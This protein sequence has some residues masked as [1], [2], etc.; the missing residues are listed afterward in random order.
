MRKLLFLI[1][2]YFKVSFSQ[3]QVSLI[4][5]FSP[6]TT[7]A[8]SINKLVSVNGTLYFTVDRLIWKSDGTENGT[9]RLNPYSTNS[10]YTICKF[11]NKLVFYTKDS[12]FI[13]DGT[14]IGTKSLMYFPSL[15]GGSEGVEFFEFGNYLYFNAP[16]QSW[17]STDYE[18]WRTDGTKAGTS[19]VKDINLGTES[20][21]PKNFQI[22]NNTT[23]VFSAYTA[24]SGT[25]IWK[26]DGTS[27]GTVLLHDIISGANSSA[28]DRITKVGNDVFFMALSPNDGTQLWRTDGVNLYRYDYATNF[29]F[30]SFGSYIYDI[31]V[32]NNE[33]YLRMYD[34]ILKVNSQSQYTIPV[35][36]DQYYSNFSILNGKLILGA[37]FYSQIWECNLVN[38]NYTS[39]IK[40]YSIIPRCVSSPASPFTK[41]GNK[42]FFSS[43]T[44]SYAEE[45]WVTDGT[46]TGTQ[47]VKDIN[48]SAICK[49]SSPTLLTDVNGILFFLAN[50]GIN[51]TQLWKTDGTEMGTVMVKNIY[52]PSSSQFTNVVKLNNKAY[53]GVKENN[54]RYY[55]IW[56]SDATT[57]G[58][59][60]INTTFRSENPSIVDMKDKILLINKGSSGGSDSLWAFNGQN[61]PVSL[62]RIRDATNFLN[63]KGFTYFISLESGFGL[64]YSLFRTNG[65]VSGTNLIASIYSKYVGS[66]TYP[67]PSFFMIN[68]TLFIS[69]EDSYHGFY[70]NTGGLSVNYIASLPQDQD[71][72]KVGS[73]IFNGKYYKS[74]YDSIT[75]DELYSSS[76]LIN[77]TLVKDITPGVGITGIN[78]LQILNNKI[79][80]FTTYDNF[81]YRIILW[82]SDG[83]SVG[84]KIIKTFNSN[85]KLKLY[86]NLSK[87]GNKLY[88]MYDDGIHGEEIWSSDGTNSGTDLLIDFNEGPDGAYMNN[89]S[90]IGKNIIFSGYNGKQENGLEFWKIPIG[91]SSEYMDT[92]KSGNWNENSTWSCG[93]QPFVTDK[94]IINQNH[95]I[96]LSGEVTINNITLNGIINYLQG[97]KL[98]LRNQ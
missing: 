50:D 90:W 74:K 26:S 97:G 64:S 39:M 65:T 43:A 98:N 67:P 93:T 10:E 63:Y 5:D 86:K 8:T 89:Y 41:S 16:V 62:G 87:I 61:N 68:D 23:F 46:S 35:I 54:S 25:E 14:S 1:V 24:S 70:Y 56:Q 37:N 92:A 9:N 11:K 44:G 95:T 13:T 19:L 59:V 4:K 30:P 49:S 33:M 27:S 73:V 58:T 88:F 78:D 84:T 21:N 38:S 71:A 3:G 18:L 22:L 52:Y 83:T 31:L 57:T 53:F 66:T 28:P 91:C 75:G 29:V 42:I 36:I 79:L 94:I 69:R 12:V 76:D 7:P 45:L 77:W 47:L 81:Q 32:Y 51:G 20:S 17:L 55:R 80:F 72:T 82:E 2:I 48:T 96:N 40:D 60:L 34:K 6:A 15:S 85:L